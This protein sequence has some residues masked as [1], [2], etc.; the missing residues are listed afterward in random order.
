MSLY[1]VDKLI[2]EAR[3][4]AAEYRRTTGGPLPG[5]S[6]EIARHDAVRLLDL[7]LV[8]NGASY[9]ATGNGEREGKR[10]QIKG[11]VIQDDNQKGLR[12]GQIKVEQEWD[13]VVLVLLDSD[14][15]PFEVY[16][17]DRDDVV[18]ASASSSQN[19]SKRGAM[20]LARFKAIA[21]LA[22][23]REDGLVEDGVWTNDDSD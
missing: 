22:W 4:L 9:D 18:E 17:V 7:T 14:Y 6:G 19:R 23:T 5:I 20:T 13:S 3:Q 11:R 10:I 1:S 12:I 2:S 21:S 15:E 8:E 16:E